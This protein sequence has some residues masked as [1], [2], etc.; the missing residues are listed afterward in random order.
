MINFI[1]GLLSMFLCAIIFTKIKGWIFKRT[2]FT[3]KELE[4][5]KALVKGLNTLK[6]K[7]GIEI[8]KPNCS[9]GKIY[10]KKSFNWN[11]FKDNFTI[12]KEEGKHWGKTLAPLLNWRNWVLILF[13]CGILYGYGYWKGQLGKPINWKFNHKEEIQ[14]NIPEDAVSFDKPAN[15]S[16]AYWIDKRGEKI[17]VTVGDS[18][19]ISEKLKPYGFELEPFFSYGIAI[20]G[21]K[22][23]QDVGVGVAWLRYKKARIA[24]WVSNNAVW[25]GIDYSITRNFGLLGGLGKGWAGDNL[26]G[27]N[28]RWW[29]N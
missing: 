29:F 11:K 20:G 8:I 22:P 3:V 9:V 5:G 15:S 4:Q 23:K 6:G 26:I 17:Q 25:I 18:K 28:T 7:V 1:L 14:F 16:T 19:Y 27:I 12:T 24:N 21:D 2:K 13:G 10:K